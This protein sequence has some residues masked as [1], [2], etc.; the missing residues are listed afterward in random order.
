MVMMIG[1][2]HS[3]I[4]MYSR[5]RVAMKIGGAIDDIQN[6]FKK[7]Q[8]VHHHACACMQVCNNQHV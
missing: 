6:M 3:G 4:K 5:K 2:E 7:Q 8:Y 1:A